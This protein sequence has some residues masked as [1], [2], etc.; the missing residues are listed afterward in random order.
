MKVA[1]NIETR[2]FTP[3]TTTPE[4]KPNNG[5]FEIGAVDR[6]K[7]EI[8]RE[9][10]SK[11]FEKKLA[12]YN[13]DESVARADQIAEQR[14]ESLLF[15]AV[16]K[17]LKFTGVEKSERDQKSLE[18]AQSTENFHKLN[19]GKISKENVD[20]LVFDQ[21]FANE[22][23]S[24]E[25][26]T[27]KLS[28]G[29]W[30]ERIGIIKQNSRHLIAVNKDW[31]DKINNPYLKWSATRLSDC[32]H[33][34][35]SA[36]PGVA[37]FIGVTALFA[38]VAGLLVSSVAG[39]ATGISAIG[40]TSKYLDSRKEKA[41]LAKTKIFEYLN[42][43][44]GSEDF[45]MENNSHWRKL[46]RESDN[47]DLA[48]CTVLIDEMEKKGQ[49]K[50]N[51][52]E[53]VKSL[54]LFRSL[55]DMKIAKSKGQMVKI[56]ASGKK[57]ELLM[58]AENEK[59]RAEIAGKYEELGKSVKKASKKE[60]LD[61]VKYSAKIGAVAA[62]L[63]WVF[64]GNHETLMAKEAVKNI[65][66]ANIDWN[67]YHDYFVNN[68]KL[69]E[70]Q[71]Q[72]LKMFLEKHPDKLGDF[73]TNPKWIQH[74]KNLYAGH[75]YATPL[76][77][78]PGS[79]N[80]FTHAGDWVRFKEL[81]VTNTKEAV[82]F[83]NNHGIDFNTAVA[84]LLKKLGNPNL[85][86]GLDS[87]QNVDEFIK[88]VSNIG[89]KP[90]EVASIKNLIASKDSNLSNTFANDTI[91]N[92]NN[93]FFNQASPTPTHMPTNS[94]TPTPTPGLTLTPNTPNEIKAQTNYL[95]WICNLPVI[96][97]VMGT[98][99]LGATA[100]FGYRYFNKRGKISTTP[101]V[102][103][104]PEK[105]RFW[106]RVHSVPVIGNILTGFGYV[107]NAGLK[108]IGLKKEE[109]AK[110]GPEEVKV[111]KPKPAKP[112]DV[113]VEKP[114]ESKKLEVEGLGEPVEIKVEK[115]AEPVEVN[116]SKTTRPF[117][118]KVDKPGPIEINVKK[119]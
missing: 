99:V 117:E 45:D 118:V 4:L 42:T 56:E 108:K 79:L 1:M 49:L 57:G 48:S 55:T 109:T 47:I 41:R 11:D 103:K 104:K 54:A 76:M 34:F 85:A 98:L 29:Q 37:T 60:M 101:K 32:K 80:G 100:L 5:I 19:E 50:S 84:H 65:K 82:K 9:D 21:V 6:L 25:T 14:K 53:S 90:D 15:N 72:D 88:N 44:Y 78:H 3:N 110:V 17:V 18:V 63:A 43:K 69:S 92:L 16:N 39:A 95:G 97:S 96:G 7:Q 107:W 81:L 27:K 22:V 68:F 102:E 106:E 51:D 59:V 35:L 13:P 31:K 113:K 36:G 94:P 71:F 28:A 77:D 40:A 64:G 38:P 2:E 114:S 12:E 61:A 105:K 75:A 67:Q 91:K 23:I 70:A 73:L 20:K 26:K 30:R 66:L 116:V 10:L 83:A 112:M 111:P 62:V 52:I 89:L 8:S 24:E 33:F 46:I 74:V 58:T 119:L 93:T 86:N 115:T 87:I